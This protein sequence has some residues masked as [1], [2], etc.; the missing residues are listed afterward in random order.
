MSLATWGRRSWGAK[1]SRRFFS[2]FRWPSSSSAGQP[3]AI[4]R[5]SGGGIVVPP[6]AE[7][8][9]EALAR[10]RD[11]ADLAATLGRRG[12]EFAADLSWDRLAATLLAAGGVE[13]A[14]TALSLHHGAIHPTVNLDEPGEGCDLDFVADGARE[15]PLKAALCNSF[16]FGGTNASLLL[17]RFE[18]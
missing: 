6:E 12:H 3:A 8:L 7:A 18:G 14:I 17:T 5:D 10:L 4:V 11:D 15:I 1:A 16:G 2:R 13:T 9:A